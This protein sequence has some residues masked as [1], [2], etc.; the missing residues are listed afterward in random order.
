MNG[1]L[2]LD[3]PT[4]ITSHDACDIVK[5]KLGVKKAG[6]A[7]TLDPMV[8]GVLVIALEDSTKALRLF[9]G[10]EKEYQGRAHV[11]ADFDISEVEKV[12]NNK[13]LGKIKQTPPKRSRVKREEREREI[14]DFKILDHDQRNFEFSVLCQAGT[15][16]RKLIDDLG[17]EM[18]IAMHMASLRRT[19]Q[20]PFSEEETIKVEDLNNRDKLSKSLLSLGQ[21]VK[22]LDIKI[23]QV[24]DEQEKMIKQGK[25]IDSDLELNDEELVVAVNKDK[26]IALMEKRENKLKPER[27]L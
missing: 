1:I 12:I 5:Q 11:H 13:F 27:V 23:V 20:G 18:K 3:K 9:N 8:T 17:K 22:R 4:G 24:S 14:F 6:H 15:Y 10:L 19:K 25:F 2:I 26:V 21:A 16:I 7:G